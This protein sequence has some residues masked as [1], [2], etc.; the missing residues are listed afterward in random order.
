MESTQGAERRMTMVERVASAIAR[1]GFNANFSH[2]RIG[3]Q[4]GFIRA[5]LGA[6]RVLMEPSKVMLDA[7]AYGSGEDCPIVAEGAIY[8]ALEA[9]IEEHEAAR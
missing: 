6:M 9:A 1:D 3:D 2:C 5:A 7:G 8:A 4:Q